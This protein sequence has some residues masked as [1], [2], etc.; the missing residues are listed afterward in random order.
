M[1]SAVAGSTLGGSPAQSAAGWMRE[2]AA[3]RRLDEMRKR[4]FSIKTTK[5]DSKDS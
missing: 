4:V 1:K 2:L 3:L 5:A